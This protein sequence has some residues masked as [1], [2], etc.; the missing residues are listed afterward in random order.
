MDMGGTLDISPFYYPLATFGPCTVNL[1]LN[2]RTTVRLLPYQS[3]SVRVSSSGF[4][5]AAFR[6]DEIPFEHPLGLMLAVAAYYRID[7]I[8]MRIDSPAPVKSAL[9]GSSVAAVAAIGAYQTLFE[10]LGQKPLSRQRIARLAHGIEEAA[11]AAT[12]GMQDQLAAVYGGVHAWYWQGANCDCG[13]QKEPLC[14]REKHSSLDK[15]FLLAYCGVPHESKNINSR[16][17]HQF[18]SGRYYRQ[19]TDILECTQAFA[20]ALRAFDFVTAAGWMNR[21]TDI[22]CELTPDVF[23]DTG[24][25]LVSAA[26][27]LGCGA[28]FCGAGGGGC[29]WAI[30]ASDAIA[31]VKRK[32]QRITEERAGSRLIAAGIDWQGLQ[33]GGGA[34]S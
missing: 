34:I 14:R 32:W 9:G 20:G 33:C 12:C 28:R 7:G 13:F 11:A 17:I 31:A 15:S 26:R 18:L 27:N 8:H 30:G 16:W 24:R 1:A 2:L 10:R 5:S 23:D 6:L 3:G 25:M 22:R 21:E 4:E 19:W 29:I